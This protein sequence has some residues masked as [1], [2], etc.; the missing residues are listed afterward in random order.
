MTNP[1]EMSPAELKAHMTGTHAG[2][3]EWG[4]SD[5]HARYC[6]PLKSRRRCHCG[7][8]G[9][10]THI[11]MCNGVGLV[12]GCELKVMRWVRSAQW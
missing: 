12:W 11:G 4:S 10:K 7:C 1:N 5:R 9:R 8:G 6:E 3:G 2:W